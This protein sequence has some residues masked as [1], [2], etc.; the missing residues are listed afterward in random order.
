MESPDWRA[1]LEVAIQHA[2]ADLSGLPERPVG[3]TATL[4]RLREALGGPLPETGGPPDEVVGALAAAAEPG[5][6]ATPSGRFFGFVVGGTMPGSIDTA[7][8]T[9]RCGS[10]DSARG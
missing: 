4:P 6:L 9:A 3:S 2:M 1:P 7:R 8:S 10:L 5:L